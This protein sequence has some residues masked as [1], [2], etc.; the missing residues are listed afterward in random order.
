MTESSFTTS[1]KWYG[2]YMWSGVLVGK[3]D[4]LDRAFLT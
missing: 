4:R 3:A 1:G 2:R